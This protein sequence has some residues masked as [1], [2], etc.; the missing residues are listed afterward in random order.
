VKPTWRDAFEFLYHTGLRKGELSNLT[1][2]DVD[3]DHDQ[4]SIAIQAK[5]DWAT[6]P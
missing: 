1:W 4:P 5:E 3:I 6:K 2:D